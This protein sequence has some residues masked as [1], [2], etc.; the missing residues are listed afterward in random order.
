MPAQSAEIGFLSQSPLTAVRY[1]KWFRKAF[2]FAALRTRSTAIR[3]ELSQLACGCSVAELF[4]RI[5]PDLIAGRSAFDPHKTN[6]PHR[7]KPPLLKFRR[8]AEVK[9]CLL[10]LAWLLSNQEAKHDDA[11]RAFELYSWLQLRYGIKAL[12]RMHRIDLVLLTTRLGKRPPPQLL[13]KLPTFTPADLLS[14]LPQRLPTIQV[15]A[16]AEALNSAFR[17]RR[18]WSIPLRLLRHDL[19]NPW[20]FAD[21]N[22]QSDWVARLGRLILPS[23]AAGLELAGEGESPFDRLQ[24]V[25]AP[26]RVSSPGGPLVSVVVSC[27]EP[28]SHLVTAVRSVLA[29]TYQNL[30]VLVIDDSSPKAFDGLLQRVSKLDS[31]VKV[32]KQPKNGGT[33][34]IRNRAL[35]EAAGELITFHDSDDWMHPERIERQVTRLIASKHPANISMSMRCSQQ[36][37]FAEASRRFRLGLCEPSLLFRRQEVTRKIGYFDS[38]R[39]GAD[40][41]YRQRLQR[42]YGLQ[43]EVIEPFRVLT[44]QRA[45]NGGLTAGDLGYRWITEFRLAYRDSFQKWHR[46]KQR[47]YVENSEQRQFFAPRQMR[48]TNAVAS[49]PREFDLI[50]GA[51]FCDPINLERAL[52]VIAQAKA[53]NRSVACWQLYGIYP[54]QQERGL[55]PRFLDLLDNGAVSTLYPQDQV[56]A[57]K[58]LLIAPSAYLTSHR[59]QNFAWSISAMEIEYA[60]E[61]WR[62][63]SESAHR[64][65]EQLTQRDFGT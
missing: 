45:D 47:L 3:E 16:I 4:E 53:D 7:P 12:P 24:A 39:K 27:Y 36:L 51:N 18:D 62:E 11:R 1:R 26:T 34:R 37:E 46:S 59:P 30:E 58:L 65:V 14:R 35:D 60:Q 61:S 20:R 43:L 32:L 52:A 49:A 17:R 22:S 40:S 64:V 29:S 8:H 6:S 50:L 23:G 38:V 55:N 54:L 25:D 15:L 28:S 56:Q 33:Y 21:S 41:E 13:Q 19:N 5:S 10:D 31:R 63:A 42:A 2:L 44:L 57:Q 48:F 9:N